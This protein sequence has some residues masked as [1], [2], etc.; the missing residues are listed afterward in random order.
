MR[1]FVREVGLVAVAAAL[2][3]WSFLRPPEDGAA[4]ARVPL[5]RPLAVALTPLL[6]TPPSEDA[7]APAPAPPPSAAEPE[8]RPADPEPSVA[9]APPPPELGAPDEDADRAEGGDLAEATASAAEPAE[10]PRET[11]METLGEAPNETPEETPEETPGAER[12]MED[13]ELLAAARHELSGEAR[14]GFATVLLA[15][16]EEQ[17]EIARFF[18]EELVLVPRSALDPAAPNPTYFRLRPDGKA[19]VEAVA[20]RAPLA[21]FRQYRDLFDYEYSRLPAPLRELRRSVLV[22]SEVYL[23]AALIPAREWAVVIGRRRE[24]LANTGRDLSEVRRFLLRYVRLSGGGYDL[25]VEEIVFA[26]GGRSRQPS[27][28]I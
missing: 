18:G 23:F 9:S 17:L 14:R 22:R 19:G 5:P 15:S 20:G 1:T 16:P 7:P 3:W 25:R 11:P 26:D 4:T 6:E 13:A 12:L 8:A 2:T 21:G 10:M 24:A 27:E 28:G